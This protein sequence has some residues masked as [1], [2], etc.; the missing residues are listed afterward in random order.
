MKT[1]ITK[2]FSLTVAA[3]ITASCAS[4]SLIPGMGSSAK[5]E[6]IV[7]AADAF[8]KVLVSCDA[9]KIATYTNEEKDSSAVEDLEAILSSEDYTD[10]QMDIAEAVADTIEYEI[11]EDSVK[12]DKDEAS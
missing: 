10:E 5:T 9:G 2:I 1:N 11:D 12:I 3:A 4:C 8:A 6:D 7:D